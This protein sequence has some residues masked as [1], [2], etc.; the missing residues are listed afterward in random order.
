MASEGDAPGARAPGPGEIGPVP[1]LVLF[2]VSGAAALV[3]QVVWIRQLSLT[4]SV[5][6]Y[7]LT[8]VLCAFMAGLALGAALAGQIADRLRR[9]LVAF[10]LAEIGIAV[11]GVA[12]P[13][14]LYGLS[15]AYVW[16]YHAFGGSG[17]G[18]DLSRFLLAF[19][20]LIVPTTLMGTTLPM[21]A[22]AIIGRT[23][24][25]GRRAGALYAAN[26]L[27]AVVGVV[28]AGFVL[29]P[30]FGLQ[31]TSAGA[32][33]FN[34][35]IGVLA[36]A[37]G[38]RRRLAPAATGESAARPAL[39][40]AARLAALAFGVSGFAAMGYEVLWTR[41]LEH[42]THN[43]TYAYSAMLATFLAG[44]GLGSAVI[45]RFADRIERP[46]FAI[47]LVQ[48]G[49]GATVVAALLL[50]ARFETLIPAIAATIGGLTSWSRVVALIF[51]EAGSTMLATTLLLGAMFP[52]VAKVVVDSVGAV[53]RRIGTAYVANTAGSILGA[54]LVGFVL[55]P[56]L[57][58]RGAFVS[59]VLLN[60]GVAVLL[61]FASA[62]RSRAAALAGAAGVVAVV[63]FAVVPANL[64][65]EQFRRRFGILRFYRE[66]VTDTVMVTE[67]EDGHRMIRYGDG[68][69]TAGTWTAFEDR[70]YAHIPM[71]LHEDP[72]RVLQIGFG[73]GNTL[74]SV[75]RYPIESATC[76][77][78]SPGVIDA[79]PFFAST[80]FDVLENPKVR[81]VINDGRNF[82]LAS[83]ETW[84]VIRLDPPELHTA[85]VV[86]LYTR[87]FYEMAL[88][89]LAPGGIFSIWVNGVMTP[90]DG[91][92][93]IVQTIADVFP[94]VSV[95]HGPAGYS[96]V[97]NGSAEPHH[98]NLA[99]MG[100]RFADPALREGL[101]TIGIAEPFHFLSHFMFAGEDV[102]AFAGDA[103]LVTDDQTRLDF[104]APR[105][106]DSFFGI[107]NVNSDYWLIQL[108]RPGADEDFATR[109]FLEKVATLAREKRSVLPHVRGVEAAG[110]RRDQ[111]PKMME[112]SREARRAQQAAATDGAL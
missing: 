107:A 103:P 45:S 50:Y 73:V 76:A 17:L 82:L 96:W 48:L 5:T 52:L 64:L 92:R 26:T 39:P 20:V 84:D 18:F 83:D 12:V 22:R 61:A 7:A 33:S 38:W 27:G 101:A 68:R 11:C 4:L 66:E 72:K 91:L 53:G 24:V 93:M 85:G 21:L 105:S 44:I 2:T 109:L 98:P 19:A 43:S 81:L 30:A 110:I 47:A 67:S 51:G 57:G 15:D 36:I 25:V 77:E 104:Q 3:Y 80:N 63:A 35:A 49:I 13:T 65:E 46:L 34:T 62:P 60:L 9:P 99:R 89:H 71:L 23:D 90:V 59:L 79:A 32:A 86:N 54:L 58:V 1:L 74:A 78:L 87:E 69:G 100:E 95:W 94:H 111:L 70:M 41:S 42:F 97:I 108:I 112:I 14:I 28:L 37:L 10:G 8:T 31:A 88:A 40:R 106:E 55:L 16:L 102:A 6:V 56:A 75:A 29:I